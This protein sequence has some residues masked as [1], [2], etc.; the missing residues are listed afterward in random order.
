MYAVIALL[1]TYLVVLHYECICKI[2]IVYLGSTKYPIQVIWQG[3][4]KSVYMHTFI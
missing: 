4:S 3:H 2:G 1:N